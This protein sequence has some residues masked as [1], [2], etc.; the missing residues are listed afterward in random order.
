MSYKRQR[1]T[2][3]EQIE[4]YEYGYITVKIPIKGKKGD[5]PFIAI[6]KIQPQIEKVIDNVLHESEYRYIRT[7]FS[8]Q[9]GY[10]F[11][12]E[13]SESMLD[14]SINLWDIGYKPL[15]FYI[16]EYS[17]LIPHDMGEYEGIMLYAVIDIRN[18]KKPLESVFERF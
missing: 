17:H 13:D 10:Y 15:T 11:G 7:H 2:L 18:P 3:E 4:L 8:L 6:E 5:N 9:I 14:H 12:T 1:L 16:S